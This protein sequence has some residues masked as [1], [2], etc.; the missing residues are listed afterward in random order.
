MAEN[1]AAV[2]A[3]R[4][5]LILAAAVVA[6]WHTLD[7]VIEEMHAYTLITYLPAVVVLVVIAAIG[8][9]WRRGPELPIHD[10]QTDVI[11]GTI[12]LIVALTLSLMNLRYSRAYLTTHVDLLGLW[13][14]LLGSSCLM[15]GLRP[16]ARYRWVWLLLLMI[17]PVPYRVEVL[18][19]GG[20]P[21]VA[22]G[23]MVAFGAAATAVATAR[24]PRRGLFGAAIAGAV[25]A[26]ALIGLRLVFPN[27]SM[28]AYQTVP[29]VGAALVASAWLYID[30]RRRQGDSWSPLGRA[31]S[32]VSVRR[33]GR[34][35]FLVV[36]LAVAM[37][38]IPIPSFGQTPNT[39]IAGLDTR[40]PVMVPP[41]WV[42]GQV[43]RYD[44]VDSLYG[45]GA[46]MTVQNIFQSKGSL[47]FDKF[48]RPRKVAVTSIETVAP[49]SFDVY[50]VIFT[51]Y[52]IG[53]RFSTSVP[54]QL[55]H[56]VTGSLQ[57]VVDDESYL[58]YNRLSWNWNNGERTQRVTLL[59]VDNH[60]PDAVFPTPDMTIA[61]NLST[62]LTVLLRGTSVTVDL[63]PQFKD[64]D[65]L[66]GCAED[67]I[68][69]QVDATGKAAS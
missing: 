67:L 23:I 20:G 43:A 62:F 38:F 54:V 52:L 12:I 66:V 27:A 14:F 1:P 68:N 33:V 47:E 53:D 4:W 31:M 16:V 15:F 51:Y 5:V 63:E 30:Y 37:F 34:P 13:M 28:M 26:V 39:H 50:P 56:G 10:R 8:V 57:S 32:P 21:L 22:G 25:G 69:A 18:T 45:P 6:F 11:V 46:T 58:T 24:T 17:W 44:W 64:R 48:A 19:F 65:L 55:P 35:G 42:A 36:V 59:S 3:I 61:R 7:A 9:S 60:D 41:G 49:L 40:P 2:V 29:A